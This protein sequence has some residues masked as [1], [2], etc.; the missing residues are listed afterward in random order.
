[1]YLK[2]V[3]MDS[4]SPLRF[5]PLAKKLW[6]THNFK[7]VIDP[8]I[9]AAITMKAL[10]DHKD[11]AILSPDNFEFYQNLMVLKAPCTAPGSNIPDAPTR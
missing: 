8:A 5:K 2:V 3:S 11:E 6:F 10:T 7:V 9:D 1:M 4:L